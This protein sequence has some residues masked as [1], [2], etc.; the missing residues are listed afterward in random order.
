MFWNMDLDED[1]ICCFVKNKGQ[2]RVEK[3]AFIDKVPKKYS[4]VK[5]KKVFSD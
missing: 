2:K 3:I 1:F 4:S 5:K